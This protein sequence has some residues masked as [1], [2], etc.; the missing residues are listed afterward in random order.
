MPDRARQ[1]MTE[2]LSAIRLNKHVTLYG[3]VDKFSPRAISTA[4]KTINV[5]M[6]AEGQLKVVLNP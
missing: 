4:E 3:T 5:D 6:L 1:L 2:N